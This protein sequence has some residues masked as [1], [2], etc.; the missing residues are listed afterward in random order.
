MNCDIDAA[1]QESDGVKNRVTG[2]SRRNGIKNRCLQT[3]ANSEELSYL[4]SAAACQ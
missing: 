3:S 2:L 4:I 1:R